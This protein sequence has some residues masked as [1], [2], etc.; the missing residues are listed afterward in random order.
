MPSTAIQDFINKIPKCF[1][2]PNQYLDDD[3]RAELSISKMWTEMYYG[4]YHNSQVVIKKLHNPTDIQVTEFRR[5]VN[6]SVQL[7]H[8]NI[9]QFYGI[10]YKDLDNLNGLVFTS[11]LPRID[12]SLSYVTE[13]LSKGTL[14]NILNEIYNLQKHVL[15]NIMLE[16]AKGMCYL[17]SMEPAII[18]RCIQ[19]NSIYIDNNFNVKITNIEFIKI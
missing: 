9:A 1:I 6:I 15:I 17:H 5:I 10:V 14:K 11:S 8:P 2:R 19:A 18:H 12:I 3:I 13:Y 16:V 4:W 7:H